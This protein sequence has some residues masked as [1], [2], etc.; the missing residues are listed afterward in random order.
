MALEEDQMKS[1]KDDKEIPFENESFFNLD[2][3][4]NNELKQM[5]TG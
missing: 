1:E 5:P 2:P 4:K 3:Y